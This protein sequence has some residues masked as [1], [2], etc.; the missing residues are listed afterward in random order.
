MK[1]Y[2]LALL[3]SCF[4]TQGFAQNYTNISYG[5]TPERELKMDIYMPKDT[6]KPVLVVWVHGGAWHSGSKENP[7]LNLLKRGYAL[8]S[9][10]YRLSIEARFPAM[11]FDILNNASVSVKIIR[12]MVVEF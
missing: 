4:I 7:P 11:L 2:F 1:R 5:L 3:F 8:A 10:D 6:D 9:I 12:F